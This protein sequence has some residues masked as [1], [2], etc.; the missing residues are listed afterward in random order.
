[1]PERILFALSCALAILAA[2]FSAGMIREG[3][4]NMNELFHG[5]SQEES[6]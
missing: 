1:M 4:R 3:A 5:V 6:E 2:A